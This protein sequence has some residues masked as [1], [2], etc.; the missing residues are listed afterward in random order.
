MSLLFYKKSEQKFPYLLNVKLRLDKTGKTVDLYT[1]VLDKEAVSDDAVNFWS[2]DE[3]FMVLH[4]QRLAV[5][6]SSKVLKF[7]SK[8]MNGRSKSLENV[9]AQDVIEIL[10]DKKNP[11]FRLSFKRWQ[12]SASFIF[13]VN[14]SDFTNPSKNT[15]ELAEFRYDFVKK[16]LYRKI[17]PNDPQSRSKFMGM[18]G[19]NKK[20][21]ILG[22]A[23]KDDPVN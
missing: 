4:G 2:P 18:I 15:A 11:R 12:D 16:N 8:P 23:M 21:F 10:T 13:S 5:I 6:A 3:E 14:K 20:G 7:L 9:T 19:K 1:R 22:G 17:D